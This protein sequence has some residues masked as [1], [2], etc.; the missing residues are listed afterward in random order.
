MAVVLVVFALSV[1]ESNVDFGSST[2]GCVV[3]SPM[4]DFEFRVVLLPIVIV[5]FLANPS[6]GLFALRFR[7][8]LHIFLSKLYV[9]QA[10]LLALS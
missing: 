2:F 4:L 9:W 6:F 3:T 1:E 7:I 8:A 5:R 10:Q